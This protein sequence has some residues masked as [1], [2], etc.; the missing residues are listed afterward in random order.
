MVFVV[1]VWLAAGM[2]GLTYGLGGV[3]VLVAVAVVA[4]HGVIVLVGGL[5]A[6]V[7]V[8]GGVVAVVVV[9]AVTV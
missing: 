1:C 4:M 2:L 7:V 8:A 9:V 3:A 5:A 6:V